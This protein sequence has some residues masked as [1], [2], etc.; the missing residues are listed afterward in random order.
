MLISN[1]DI[2]NNDF[3]IKLIA[4]ISCDIGGPIASTIRPSTI[5]K[6]L[7]GFCK[8]NSEEL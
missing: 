1:N 5:D 7:Y 4:D 2:S 8:I 3:N 6:P